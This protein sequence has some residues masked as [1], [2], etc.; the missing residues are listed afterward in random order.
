MS[1]KTSEAEKNYSSYELKTMAVVQALKKFRV[2]L[3]GVQFKVVTDCK[4]I[5]QTVYK[6]DIPPDGLCCFKITLHHRTQE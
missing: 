6:T 3:L 2:Y 5:T 4:A 1:R